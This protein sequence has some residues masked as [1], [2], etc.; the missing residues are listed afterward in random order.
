VITPNPA[1][2]ATQPVSGLPPSPS[3][4]TDPVLVDEPI[5]APPSADPGALPGDAVA[6]QAPAAD[7]SPM[8]AQ[9]PAPII[10]GQATSEPG[11]IGGLGSRGDQLDP[12]AQSEFGC[13]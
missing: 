1:P 8:V 12:A 9:G 4:P 7:S 13:D 11:S 2:P 6:S 3:G 5:A 10:I